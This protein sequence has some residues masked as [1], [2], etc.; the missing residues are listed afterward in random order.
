[1]YKS[2]RLPAAS[3]VLAAL[4][5]VCGLFAEETG[6]ERIA[7]LNAER[8]DW[9]E[10]VA[11][12][13]NYTFSR[14][15]FPSEEEARTKELGAE[16]VVASGFL[17]KAKGKCRV[18]I[19]YRNGTAHSAEQGG[20]SRTV[21]ILASDDYV[22]TYTPQQGSRRV[23]SGSLNRVYD[24]ALTTMTHALA[25]ID[26]PV[27]IFFSPVDALP[28]ET[29]ADPDYRADETEDGRLRLTL[30]GTNADG[31]TKYVKEVV[32][33]ADTR[34]ITV[35]ES[36]VRTYKGEDAKLLTVSAVK[37]YDWE[38]HG[39]FF[40]PARV[41]SYTGLYDP[42]A[43]EIDRWLVSEWKSPGLSDIRSIHEAFVLK[44]DPDVKL[45][46]LNVSPDQNVIDL[47]KITDADL[48]SDAKPGIPVLAPKKNESETSAF[49]FAPLAA[50]IAAIAALIVWGGARLR[51]KG[52]KHASPADAEG[53]G[54]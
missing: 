39:A 21:D 23:P 26:A 9:L 45:E 7:R 15:A 30:T 17:C 14:A 38:K 8:F 3:A 54:R 52:R 33:R 12:Y 29:P 24:K 50:A 6:A 19:L 13:A 11:F 44:L 40:I 22:V 32:L 1:M 46:G 20:A 5:S 10:D 18:Q 31:E 35:E 25:A 36:I 4:L 47:D 16:D 37:G 49:K 51:R 28:Y 53:D 34:P 2:F 43:G 42:S 41:R 27:S 48:D